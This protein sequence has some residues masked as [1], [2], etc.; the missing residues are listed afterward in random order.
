MSLT[1]EQWH[2]RFTQQ[3]EWTR[4]LRDYCFK[5]PGISTA[6]SI[7][8]GG[9]GTGAITSDVHRLCQASVT[10]ID[11]AYE[12][13]EFARQVDPLT[14]FYIADANHLPF[15]NQSFDVLVCHYFLLWCL[16]P[17]R[18][19]SELRRVTA[20]GGWLLILA[21]PDYTHRIDK[22]TE[23][24]ALGTAQTNALRS[25]GAHPDLGMRLPELVRKSG[26]NLIETGVLQPPSPSEKTQLPDGWDLEWSVL[27]DDLEHQVLPE[28]LSEWRDIDRSAW[29]AGIRRLEV[30]THFAIAQV[31]K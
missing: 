20:P 25:Q 12:R 4:P 18:V 5:L 22:P 9:C 10:G 3:A 27:E 16:D 15:A 29:L 17:E 1:V 31:P 24:A 2:Q 21:E 6:K 23:L 14:H 26:W 13:L 30:P 7:L 8:E 28:Q 19:L 11:I